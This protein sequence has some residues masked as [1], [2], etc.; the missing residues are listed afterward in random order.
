MDRRK[1]PRPIYTVVLLTSLAIDWYA[2]RTL[3]FG[4]RLVPLARRPLSGTIAVTVWA[5]IFRIHTAL[6]A[7]PA[8]HRQRFHWSQKSVQLSPVA[9]AALFASVSVNL[10]L[11]IPYVTNRNLSKSS[12]D[13][14][15]ESDADMRS[16]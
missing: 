9:R 2:V 6:T 7:L 13:D 4:S 14:A 5:V 10:L 16:E 1:D 12:F 8:L 15:S 11:S 3:R